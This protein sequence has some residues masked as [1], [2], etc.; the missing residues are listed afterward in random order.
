MFA[1]ADRLVEVLAGAPDPVLP[2]AGIAAR[3]PATAGD[4][5]SISI[6]VA[7]GRTEE[8]GFGR[9]LRGSELL[10][11]G[12]QMREDM[13]GERLGGTLDLTVWA[14]DASQVDRLA[15]ATANKLRGSRQALRERGFA[16]LR[17]AGLESMERLVPAPAGPPFTPWFQRLAYRF[18]FELVEGGIV[19]GGGVIRRVDVETDEPSEAFSVP[20]ST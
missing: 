14:A 7:A 13:L 16:T 9:L 19:G 10:A 20:D 3:R 17:P 11:D 1:L 8:L 18:V 6:S 12:A 5:P 15:R 2:S 4:L